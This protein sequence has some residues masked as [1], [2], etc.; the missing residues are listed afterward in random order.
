[1]QGCLLNLAELELEKI[2]PFS[3]VSHHRSCTFHSHFLLSFWWKNLL[4][5]EDVKYKS[6][7]FLNNSG[8]WAETTN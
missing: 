4:I 1:M 6:K 5:G 7:C 8:F 3:G 2:F